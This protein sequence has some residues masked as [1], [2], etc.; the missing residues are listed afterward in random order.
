MA[1][2]Q[3]ITSFFLNSSIKISKMMDYRKLVKVAQ[4]CQV[5]VQ[6]LKNTQ[7]S[8]FRETQFSKF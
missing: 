3:K 1:M 2:M 8:N 4:S 6:E 7:T 5:S